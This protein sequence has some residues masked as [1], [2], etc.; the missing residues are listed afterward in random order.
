MTVF[1]LAELTARLVAI[2]SVTGSESILADH[3]IE[4]LGPYRRVER[5]G[6]A[7]LAP[8]APSGRPVVTLVGH[9][10]TVPPQGNETPRQHEGRLY[11]RGTADMKGGLAVMLSLAATL[12]QDSPIALALVFYPEEEG[13]LA[14]NG[15]GPV[16][17][18]GRFPRT[19]L[20]IVLEPTDLTVQLGCLGTINAEA[21]FRGKSSHSARPWLGENAIHAAAGMLAALAERRSHKVLVANRLVYREV[22]SATKA[23]G[24][25][26]RNVVPDEFVLNLNFR[27]APG[28]SLDE[29][30]AELEAFVHSFGAG[31]EVVDM[32]PA[33]PICEANP[34][35][36]RLLAQGFP[37]EPKQAW[38]DVAQLGAAGIDAVNFGPGETALAHTAE[39]SVSIESLESCRAALFTLLTGGVA[40]AP[41]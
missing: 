8:P 5:V 28:K 16:L 32:A 36:D 24:G 9:L 40:I 33:G 37:V 29:A 12:P 13:P 22:I 4:M 26:A 23:L 3:V 2:P 14:R 34:I 41:V 6:N 35:L 18:S 7:V 10:D 39:E 21:L 27:F 15:L 1:D 11:G 19:D 20:A 31:I 17:S 30:L 25:N 38:T